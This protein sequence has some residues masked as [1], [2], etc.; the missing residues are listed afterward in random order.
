MKDFAKSLL[1][2]QAG[3]GLAGRLQA[4]GHSSS[5][6]QNN[7]DATGS[8]GSSGPTSTGVCLVGGYK[9]SNTS[10]SFHGQA[11][12]VQLWRTA[13]PGAHK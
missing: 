7:L 5:L 11:T 2:C 4:G 10:K 13:L 6:K 8:T 12:F 9:L 1:P 3:T